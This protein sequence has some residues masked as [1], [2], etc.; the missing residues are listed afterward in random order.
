MPLPSGSMTLIAGREATE[1]EDLYK[2]SLRRKSSASQTHLAYG[3][4]TSALTTS[5]A[6]VSMD[7]D[8]EGRLPG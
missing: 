4:S 3:S 8:D 7:D 2:V 1:D 5:C 6:S